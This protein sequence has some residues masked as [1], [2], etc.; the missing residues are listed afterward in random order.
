[1]SEESLAGLAMP[2]YFILKIFLYKVWVR[3]KMSPE[4]WPVNYAELY[5]MLIYFI[6]HIHGRA[7]KVAVSYQQSPPRP[8]ARCDYL[9]QLPDNQYRWAHCFG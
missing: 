9:A 3:K 2:T 4:L 6:S 5:S 1:M 8:V 7:S